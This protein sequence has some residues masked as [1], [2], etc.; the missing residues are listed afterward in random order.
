MTTDLKFSIQTNDIK[1]ARSN[2]IPNT[3]TRSADVRD[4][5]IF[6]YID[7]TLNPDQA[8]NFLRPAIY[9]ACSRGRL[10][11]DTWKQQRPAC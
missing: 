9:T 10:V 3:E 4:A 8:N 1:H 7:K 11:L 2:T 6:D 5:G